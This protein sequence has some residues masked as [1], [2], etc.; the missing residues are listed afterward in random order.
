MTEQ[1]LIYEM[2]QRFKEAYDATEKEYTAAIEDLEFFNG[3]QWPSDLK[4]ERDADGRPTLV[5]NKL[6]TFA[7]Q[8]IG[9]IRQNQPAITV[10][11]VDSKADPKTAEIFSGL[12]KNI[13]VQSDADV[14]YD[15]A[16]ESAVVCGFGAWRITTVYSDDDIFEQDIRVE[17]IKNPFTVY[18]DP[19]ATRWDRSDA[20]FCFITERVRKDVFI[21][22]YPNATTS[23]AEGGRD[24]DLNWGDDHN[25]RVVEYWRKVPEKKVIYLVEKMNPLTGEVTR[26]TTDM[27]P[28]QQMLDPTWKVI[29]KREVENNTLEWYKC[30]YGEI[31]EKGIWA[32]QYIPIISVYGK[33][34]NIENTSTYRGIVRHAKDSQRLYNY[35]RSSGAEIVSLAPKTPFLVTSKQ[36]GNYS[37]LWDNAH[38]KNYPYLPYD[39]DPGNPQAIPHRSDP[40]MVNTGINNEI[41]IAD[42]EL[43]DTTGLQQASL[44][45]KSNEKSGRAIIARQQE[46]D[47]AN[48]AYYD[49]LG[50]ALKYAG[51][52]LIDLIPKIYDTARI[53]R[54]INQDGTDA[55]VPINA[56]FVN[57]Q[58]MEQVFDLTV[59]KYDVVVSIGPSYTTQREE[60]AENM[61]RFIQAVPQA[62]ML[63]VDLFAKSLD[64]PGADKIEQRLK[65]MLPPQLQAQMEGRP[66][67]PDPMQMQ[68]QALEMK[69][70]EAEAQGAALDSEEKFHRVDRMKRGL[71]P[72]PQPIKPPNIGKR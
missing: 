60:T 18:W 27:K 14:A 51:R 44:G 52:V 33:E 30:T 20:K 28:N 39:V 3:D 56:P 48:F 6:P 63:L 54:V 65:M 13:E 67:T 29:N 64:W 15:T 8:V 31:L 61:L 32:G 1:E 46:G 10:K 21:K 24:T 58:G 57:Q 4:A 41:M 49:N 72:E 25:V 68:M 70:A 34:V 69:K 23:D 62:G 36:I 66:P 50:R 40:I 59:G 19:A 71:P 42:Q 12:I 17:R 9:D 16:A 38:R 2:R 22:Q 45:K 26:Y 11:P 7:D 53:V 5:I 47:I 43:H 35:S 37:K 55:T